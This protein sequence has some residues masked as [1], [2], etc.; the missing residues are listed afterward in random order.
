MADFRLQA[1][2][3]LGTHIYRNRAR[4][5]GGQTEKHCLWLKDQLDA[6]LCYVMRLLL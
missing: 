3:V 1:L 4:K 6:Q 2:N 5:T